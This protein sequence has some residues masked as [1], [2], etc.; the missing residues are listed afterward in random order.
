MKTR[1]DYS[2]IRPLLKYLKDSRIDKTMVLKEAL[3]TC[4]FYELE[5]LYSRVPN[6][7][8]GLFTLSFMKRKSYSQL[9]NKHIQPNCGVVDYIGKLSF[10]LV[11][12]SL[13]IQSF[14]KEREFV[15]NMVALGQYEKAKEKLKKIDEQI[16]YSY[17]S[18]TYQI[19]IDR[20]YYGTQ[21]AINTH[22]SIY[23]SNVFFL[24]RK[25]CNAAFYSSTLDYSNDAQEKVYFRGE[26]DSIVAIN[27]I[28]K[29]HCFAYDGLV[30]GKWICSDMNSSIIDLYNHFI[31]ML[32][33]L[34]KETI[35]NEEFREY[36]RLI[37]DS[38]E[39]PYLLKLCKLWNIES[40]KK[41]DLVVARI[42]IINLYLNRDY[43][44]VIEL[45]KDYIQSYPLDIDIF[46]IYIKSLLSLGNQLPSFEK[47]GALIDRIRYHLSRILQ[48]DRDKSFHIRKLKGICIAFYNISEF[49]FLFYLI[50]GIEGN[51][52]VGFYRNVW[53]YSR[54]LNIED[55]LCYSDLSSKI[56]FLQV[57]GIEKP[58]IENII[59]DAP[60]S[61]D[62]FEI[63][64]GLNVSEGKYLSFIDAYMGGNIASYV[65]DAAASYFFDTYIRKGNYY[66]AICFYVEQVL[67]DSS[68]IISTR[69]SQIEAIIDR[70]DELVE[71]DT[72]NYVIFLY[73]IN[74]EINTLYLA[75]KR[76]LK[77]KGVM[78]ASQIEVV[79][80]KKQDFFLSNIA[81]PKVL[82]LHVLRFKSVKQVMQERLEICT[83]LYNY[84]DDKSYADEISG[85]IRDMRM[86]E[87]SNQIDDSKIYVDIQSIKDVELN[88]AKALYK[89]YEQSDHDSELLQ[90]GISQIVDSLKEMGFSVDVLIDGYEKSVERLDYQYKVLRRMFIYV[91]N[92]FLFNPKSGLDNYLSTRIRHGT[93]INQL[94]NHYENDNL[95]TNK[96]NGL[97]NSNTFWLHNVFGLSGETCQSC[98]SFFK[99]F[100][101]NTDKLIF[102]IK[103]EF[104]QVLTEEN[105]ENLSA[106]FDYTIDHFEKGIEDLHRRT[107]LNSYEAILSEMINLLWLR[108]DECLENIKQK[109]QESQQ[110]MLDELQVLEK[111]VAGIIERNNNNW[112]S[113]H[114]AITKCYGEIQDDFQVVSRWFNRGSSV[115]F[116][117]TLIQVIN[118]C[119]GFINTNSKYELETKI[120]CR[121]ETELQGKYF[122]TLY[123]MFHDIMN[124][125]L[126]YGRE[127]SLKSTCSIDVIEVNG[128]L[129]IRVSNP[130]KD[131]D[132]QRIKDKVK[133]I[134][135]NLV[136]LLRGGKSRVEGNSGCIKIFNAVHNHLGSRNNTYVNSVENGAFIVKID[137]ELN[138]LQA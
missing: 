119:I 95:I 54:F 136:T 117:F 102:E 101:E 61:I 31:N 129:D 49:R 41:V 70:Y 43:F 8:K 55:V 35:A 80:D 73:L 23:N 69:K 1:I 125:I 4:N 124:N 11:H 137:L 36:L 77:T 105:S 25:Y 91:R 86:L 60:M 104:V 45:S 123:D 67:E 81:T 113:F 48:R 90:G 116:D 138:P 39:D 9:F 33:A 63:S 24:L 13:T 53:K 52:I 127:H 17:W 99:I 20:L 134:N 82:T 87:L 22:N 85:I 57:I 46:L 18:K 64:L 106:C 79:G 111:N 42:E 114:D 3:D 32:T 132:E 84:Y 121:S 110:K 98:D 88:E 74:A 107:E 26:N 135:E 29:S 7:Y 19:K 100:S 15:D 75:Y 30:E 103:D 131:T 109:L 2:K 38:I 28:I 130:I 68:L 58:I 133:E 50:I 83:N 118:A 62:C 21:V 92:Q 40:E 34:S 97:Y 66:R 94:R 126:Y 108:T 10:V 5:Y 56:N 72:I 122:A 120:N 37:T 128:L 51:E 76:Y 78:K 71:I 96:S 12:N 89:M 44:R 47:E 14:I 59:H 27:N 93:L 6:I 115:N 65:K 16:S 112:Y